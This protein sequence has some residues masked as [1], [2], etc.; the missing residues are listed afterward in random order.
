MSSPVS[1]KAVQWKGWGLWSGKTLQNDLC[2][3]C[4]S[5]SLIT[6]KLVWIAI[7]L[8]LKISFWLI[9]LYLINPLKLVSEVI[10]LVM[11]GPL[12]PFKFHFDPLVQRV[13]FKAQSLI[14]FHR[15]YWIFLTIVDTD[16]NFHM[17][18][19]NIAIDRI[20]YERCIGPSRQ[21]VVFAWS[22]CLL[23]FTALF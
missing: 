21:L 20:V 18:V 7:K 2:V 3:K 8:V 15:K 13:L 1:V 5:L 4:S 22:H 11:V 19:D 12:L 6:K 23:V 16:F 9:W 10:T 14:I 17:H